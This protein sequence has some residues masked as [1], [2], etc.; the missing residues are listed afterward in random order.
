M[1]SSGSVVVILHCNFADGVAFSTKLN[2]CSADSN[3]FLNGLEN[4]G[5]GRD[6]TNYHEILQCRIDADKSRHV[7]DR[8]YH[9]RRILHKILFYRTKSS[10]KLAAHMVKS[11][12]CGVV[13]EESDIGQR[14]SSILHISKADTVACT[15]LSLCHASGGKSCLGACL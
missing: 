8:L 10:C 13:L 9:P 3:V 5:F 4:G 2:G 1:L 15:A 12:N 7:G 14:L 6:S 11:K